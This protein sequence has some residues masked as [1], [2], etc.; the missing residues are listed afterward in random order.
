M[1][2][3]RSPFRKEPATEAIL[4]SHGQPSRF[5]DGE[6]YL[7]DLARRVARLVPDWI[8]KSATLAAPAALDA[9]VADLPAGAFVY[10]LFMTEGWFTQTA[11]TGRLEGR[12]LHQL[13]AFGCHPELPT[14]TSRLILAALTASGRDAAETEILLAAHGSASGPAAG[15]CTLQ[16]AE[17]L[18][19]KLPGSNIRVGFLEQ[20]PFLA[21]VATMCSQQAVCLPFFAGNGFHVTDDVPKALEKGHFAGPCLAPLGDAPFLPELIAQTLKSANERTLAA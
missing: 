11:L 19:R 14:L 13:P 3:T 7:N 10:P 1:S 8:I 18:A 20:S 2:G 4:V 5:E 15:N 12:H 9:A 16:F 17:K 21:D 6:A